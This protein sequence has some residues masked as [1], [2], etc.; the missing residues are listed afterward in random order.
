MQQIRSLRYQTLCVHFSSKT[1]RNLPSLSAILNP[2]NDSSLISRPNWPSEC[3]LPLLH[4]HPFSGLNDCHFGSV[5]LQE[6]SIHML[7]MIRDYCTN[8]A[9]L[10]T[11]LY[12]SAEM[13]SC[14]D[15]ADS[16]RAAG[17]ALTLVDARFKAI[18]SLKEVIVNLFDETPSDYLRKKIH[19]CGWTIKVIALEESDGVV[20]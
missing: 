3:K 1:A 10:E 13:E 12:T 6:D 18:P 8:I 7:E 15:A 4:L 16:P 14:L 20:L 2:I 17:E 9:T 11:L 19:K 5:T